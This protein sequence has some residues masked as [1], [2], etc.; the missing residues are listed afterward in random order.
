MYAPRARA[1]DVC[2]RNSICA[3]LHL[4]RVMPLFQPF[5]Y[6]G[7]ALHP[8]LL[9]PPAAFPAKRVAVFM[10]QRRGHGV[11]LIKGAGTLTLVALVSGRPPQATLPSGT[12]KV[13][14]V[15]VAGSSYTGDMSIDSVVLK[16]N[17]TPSCS[18]SG[19]RVHWPAWD[20]MRGFNADHSTAGGCARLCEATPN[21]TSFSR[22][23]APTSDC[24]L[25]LR[26]ERPATD[27]QTDHFKNGQFSVRE[28]RRLLLAA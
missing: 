13:R 10:L 21:C 27:K 25:F 7:M 26:G 14:F 5:E 22:R 24:T 2:V 19:D 23:D 9:P 1:S 17:T 16:P 18:K 3:P 20:E 6:R 8:R 15:A 12:S 4:L 11:C 28:I